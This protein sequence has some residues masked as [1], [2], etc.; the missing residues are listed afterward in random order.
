MVIQLGKHAATY[1]GLIPMAG[2]THDLVAKVILKQTLAFQSRR[3]LI[4]TTGHMV[5]PRGV[6]ACAGKILT[7]GFLGS[8]MNVKILVGLDQ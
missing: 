3:L 7:A 2:F 6:T 8:H 5:I 4:N 1:V